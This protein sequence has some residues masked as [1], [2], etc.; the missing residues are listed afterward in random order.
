MSIRHP[1]I[2]PLSIEHHH[3]LR[4]ARRLRLSADRDGLARLAALA[5]L[6]EAG[7]EFERHFQDED[8]LARRYLNSAD[9]DRTRL[10][11]DHAALRDGLALADREMGEEVPD[12][13]RVL[14]L[15][16]L[17]TAHIRWVERRLFE[18]LDDFL[19]S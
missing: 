14:R 4:L 3:W 5:S 6:R 16:D 13:V 1:A 12:R 18:R 9:P 10:A 15:A 17:L 2:R 11:E 8:E 19:R 7:S